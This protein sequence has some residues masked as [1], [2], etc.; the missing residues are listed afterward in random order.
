[1]EEVGRLLTVSGICLL[2]ITQRLVD[3]GVGR[4]LAFW[5]NRQ[6]S[7]FGKSHSASNHFCPKRG[8]ERP[9][10]WLER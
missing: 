4:Q 7:E 10:V 1:M 2:T 6:V 9:S 8:G 5:R 3:S